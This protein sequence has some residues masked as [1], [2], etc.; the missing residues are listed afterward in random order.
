M[1]PHF[2]SRTATVLWPAP[3]Q[4]AFGGVTFAGADRARDGDGDLAPD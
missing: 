1:V 4:V 3:S 2:G